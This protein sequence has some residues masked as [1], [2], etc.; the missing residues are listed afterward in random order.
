MVKGGL[1]VHYIK[2]VLPMKDNR[3]FMEMESGSILVV[4]FSN[5]LHTMK[6]LRLTNEKVFQSAYT[7]GDFVLWDKGK[8]RLTVNEILEIVL[9]SVC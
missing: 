1:F 7:D 3:L 6:N 2:A 9:L 4:D 5:K 8:I